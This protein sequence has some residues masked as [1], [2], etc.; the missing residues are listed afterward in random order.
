M[1][2]ILCV[3]LICLGCWYLLFPKPAD[4][5]DLSITFKDT[6]KVKLNE[7]IDQLMEEAL[8]TTEII[9]IQ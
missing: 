7:K 6:E 1:T 5:D 4:K 2:F 3:L 8:A 9:E